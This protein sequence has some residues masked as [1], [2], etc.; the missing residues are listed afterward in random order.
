[1]KRHYRTVVGLVAMTLLALSLR[2]LAS[3]I[4]EV[5]GVPLTE[6]VLMAVGIDLA[7]IACEL[8][9][10]VGVRTR[11]THGLISATCILSAGFNVLGFLAHSHGLLGQIL[12]VTLGV[13]VPSAVYGLV[14]T[15]NRTRKTVKRTKAK[16]TAT[17]RKL[18]SVA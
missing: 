11:W 14:D 4:S 3:G 7:M 16:A 17:V 6:G 8:A 5:T 13:F 1:M 10:M 2:H 9:L 12:A 15:L 18:R